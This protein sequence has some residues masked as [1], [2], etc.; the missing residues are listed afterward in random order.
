MCNKGIFCTEVWS[1]LR[2]GGISHKTDGKLHSPYS[3]EYMLTL[4]YSSST[5]VKTGC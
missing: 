1:Q 2:I 4:A 5:V 3:L